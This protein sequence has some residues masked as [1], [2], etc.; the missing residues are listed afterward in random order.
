[1][2]NIMIKAFLLLSLLAPYYAIRAEISQSDSELHELNAQLNNSLVYIDEEVGQS[3]VYLEDAL[4][5]H[6]WSSS[7]RNLCKDIR[8][9]GTVVTYDFISHTLNECFAASTKLSEIDAYAVRSTLVNY[10]HKLVDGKAHI[11]ALEDESDNDNAADTRGCCKKKKPKKICSLCVAQCLSAGALSVKGNATIGG[12]LIVGGV[13]FNTL[14]GIAGAPGVA[15]AI[16]AAGAAGAPG[17]MGVPGI[18]GIG[19]VLGWGYIYNL[20]QLTNGNGKAID[21]QALVPFDT[22]GPLNGITYTPGSGTINVTSAGTYLINFSVSGTES[23][24]FA[25]AVNGSP[26]ASTIY[27]AGAGTEQNNG[28]AIITLAANDVITLI[29]HTSATAVQLFATPP[30]GGTAAAINASIVILRIA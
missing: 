11:T 7:F 9:E 2:K 30:I 18:P 22:A 29:N 20:G 3:I 8:N 13:N 6:A 19:G 26:N 1:M 23:N 24:Q 16:G 21:P 12:T 25:I 4:P 27:G 28:Q 5:N 15:G 17:T 10:I 14:S